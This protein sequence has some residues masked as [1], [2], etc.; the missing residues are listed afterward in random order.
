MLDNTITIEG[1][2]TYVLFANVQIN[3]DGVAE[4]TFQTHSNGT[5][6]TKTPMGCFE[7]D[8]IPNDL[9]YVITKIQEYN[10]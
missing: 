9:Q 10:A 6:T 3:D 1:L 5:N 2:F 8:F 7:E 4:Y